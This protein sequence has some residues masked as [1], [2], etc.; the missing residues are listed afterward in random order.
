[1][2]RISFFTARSAGNSARIITALVALVGSLSLAGCAGSP[3]GDALAGPQKLAEQD[4]AYC[5]SIGAAH[6]TPEYQNCRQLASLQRDQRHANAFNASA[7]ALA[8][9]AAISAANN[10]APVVAIPIANPPPAPVRCRSVN[11]G[12]YAQTVCQ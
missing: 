2:K 3:I 5:R 8:A 4:D 1:M 9:G 7:N 12:T 11:Y 10:P 6:G